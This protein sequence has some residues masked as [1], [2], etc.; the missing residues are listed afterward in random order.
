[1]TYLPTGLEEPYV[2]LRTWAVFMLFLPELG[3]P[4]LHAVGVNQLTGRGR[5]SSPLAGVHPFEARVIS[6]SGRVYDLV[7]K[8]GPAGVCLAMAERLTMGWCA[9][10]MVNVSD[11]VFDLARMGLTRAGWL[12]VH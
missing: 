9:D 2:E 6:V 3:C 10:V 11:T 1:M 5:V 12:C 4:S 7:G 8:P